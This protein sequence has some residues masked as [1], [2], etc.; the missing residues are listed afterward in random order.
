MEKQGKKVLLIGASLKPFRYSHIA[1]KMLASYNHEVWPLGREK[2]EIAG[3]EVKTTLPDWDKLDTVTI[4]LN[5]ENQ[6]DYYESVFDYHP[7]RIIFNPG[8]ENP[9]FKKLAENKGVK[10]IENCTLE[11]L[12]AGIF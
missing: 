7:E 9:E 8:T 3:Q 4:Y 5:Y 1:V 10:V 2:G 11:M 12:E 6:K